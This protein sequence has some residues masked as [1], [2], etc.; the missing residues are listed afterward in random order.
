M[1]GAEKTLCTLKD[2]E[3]LEFQDLVQRLPNIAYLDLVDQTGP[4]EEEFESP[5][6]AFGKRAETDGLG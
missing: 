6:T 1:S 2:T 4:G 5:L 3:T